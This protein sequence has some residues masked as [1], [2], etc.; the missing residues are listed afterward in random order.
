MDG[1]RAPRASELPAPLS[2]AIACFLDFLDNRA[3]PSSIRRHRT[4][5]ARKRT[6]I[7]EDSSGTNGRGGKRYCISLQ[8]HRADLLQTVRSVRCFLDRAVTHFLNT[9]IDRIILWT[10]ASSTTWRHFIF[11]EAISYHSVWGI[12][13]RKTGVSTVGPVQRKGRIGVGVIRPQEINDCARKPAPQIGPRRLGFTSETSFF[14]LS[15][16]FPI[17]RRHCLRFPPLATRAAWYT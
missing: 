13:S 4:A 15:S 2:S 17:P 8:P 9:G 1:D 3:R 5:S 12:E 16:K 11:R 7:R 10:T 6:W 14:F